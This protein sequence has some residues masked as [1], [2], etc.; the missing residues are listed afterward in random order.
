MN[1]N[2]QRAWQATS[3]IVGILSIVVM[4]A[5]AFVDFSP[6][7]SLKKPSLEYHTG[8][9]LDALSSIQDLKPSISI[10]GEKFEN[11]FKSSLR[12]TN[13]GE[14]PILPEAIRQAIAIEVREPW[15]IIGVANAYGVELD[16]SRA[17]PTRYEATPALLNPKDISAFEVYV[18]NDG[19]VNPTKNDLSQIG[20]EIT[21][22]IVD[23]PQLTNAGIKNREE[24]NRLLSSSSRQPI[25]P[26]IVVLDTLDIL[27]FLLLLSAYFALYM[28]LLSLNGI[29]TSIS[30]W[31]TIGWWCLAATFSAVASESTVDLLMGPVFAFELIDVILAAPGSLL[32]DVFGPRQLLNLIVVL[33]HLLIILALSSRLWFR[34]RNNYEERQA[35]GRGA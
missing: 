1:L 6:R 9:F 21:A 26:I 17:S 15:R 25:G 34:S 20:L 29:V 18:T 22:R 4:L 23:V 14:V 31:S 11:L 2:E 35:I 27:V 30:N 3:I 28:R 8:V 33:V 7:E 12:I 16:W 13:A 32:A 5:L 19:V 24:M 10:D